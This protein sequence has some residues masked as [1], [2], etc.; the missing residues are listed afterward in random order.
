MSSAGGLA[1]LGPALAHTLPVCGVEE[2]VPVVAH[3]LHTLLTCSDTPGRSN[4]T[5]PS[6]H[7]VGR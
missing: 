5:A 7:A 6:L 4:V 2:D 1:A 3:A